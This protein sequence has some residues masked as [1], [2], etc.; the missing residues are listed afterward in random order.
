MAADH[1]TLHNDEARTT[2]RAEVL[3]QS[4]CTA[5]EFDAVMGKVTD[6]VRA[7]RVM[8]MHPEVFRKMLDKRR[9][10]TR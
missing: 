2:F 4:G 7:R 8:Q 3:A 6:F 5:E 10:Q 9:A 1:E